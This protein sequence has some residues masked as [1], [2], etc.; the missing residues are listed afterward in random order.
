MAKPP[1]G[2]ELVQVYV[3]DPVGMQVHARAELT[4][5]IEAW[6]DVEKSTRLCRNVLR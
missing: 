6:D 4:F 2:N 1:A 5:Q 3:R